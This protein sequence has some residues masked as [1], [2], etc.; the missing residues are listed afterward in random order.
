MCDVVEFIRSYT[1]ADE[2]RIRFDWNGQHAEGFVDRNMEF[3]TAVRESVLANV[4]AAPLALV[5]DLFRAETQC[6]REAWGIVEGV[7][8]L[9]ENL[10]R[11][12]GLADLDEYLEGKFQ[13]FDASL[14]S[15]FEYD[16]PLAQAMLAEVRE[17]LQSSLD[18]PKMRLW[19]SGEELFAGWVA[20]CE[21]SQAE[22][23]AA[24]DPVAK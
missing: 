22:P 24:P 7:G 21:Q 6:S 18:S 14:G 2:P 5:R 4:S 12:G 10:L 11:R 15:A 9:A 1:S 8:I 23:D 20:A 19:R 3:R 16:L 13:S 17:R